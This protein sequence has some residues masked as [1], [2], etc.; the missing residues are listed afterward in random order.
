[1]KRALLVVSI[2]ALGSFSLVTG[3]AG[4]KAP[5]KPPSTPPLATVTDVYNGS[6]DATCNS[7]DDPSVPGASISAWVQGAGLPAKMGKNQQP[8]IGLV[9]KKGCDTSNDASAD[10]TFVAVNCNGGPCTPVGLDQLP[11]GGINLTSLGFSRALGTGTCTGGSPGFDVETSTDVY[12]IGCSSGVHTGAS[13]GWEKITFGPS[14]A[15][16]LS[17]TGPASPFG[18]IVNFVQVL[19]DEAN[20]SHLDNLVVNGQVI[21]NPSC[22]SSCGGPP[23]PPGP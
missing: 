7:V 11:G 10:A 12:R 18:T 3:P 8:N 17:G 2:L 15:Q 16:H 9:L 14:D 4:A 19:Q 6:G 22:F 13:S 5:P 23:P 1:M 21:G 20:E